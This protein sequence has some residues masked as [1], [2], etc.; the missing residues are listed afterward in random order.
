MPP[1]V[2]VPQ[3]F[4]PQGRRRGRIAGNQRAGEPRTPV[5]GTGAE[6]AVEARA[7]RGRGGGTGTPGAAAAATGA[8]AR[9]GG[10]W[11]AGWGGVDG[12][13]G[14]RRRRVRVETHQASLIRV[15]VD[16]VE[17]VGRG[18]ERSEAVSDVVER[19]GVEEQAQGNVEVAVV[20]D[21]EGVDA[22]D[23]ESAC[24]SIFRTRRE[25]VHIEALPVKDG[26]EDERNGIPEDAGDVRGSEAGSH[27]SL[28]DL[29]E[30][31][32]PPLAGRRLFVSLG[33]ER[34]GDLRWRC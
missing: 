14:S 24:R 12:R 8:A 18:K 4:I 25:R 5:A 22:G 3:A 15:K 16:V 20:G 33:A 21:A 1:P 13:G 11:V 10:S 9:S 30:L 28:S 19:N 26:G 17:V 2:A 23:H 6:R 34:L 32:M 31:R 27:L 29:V 7:G